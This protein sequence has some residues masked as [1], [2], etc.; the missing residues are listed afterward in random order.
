MN[1]RQ[2]ASYTLRAMNK[3][4]SFKLGLCYRHFTIKYRLC[5]FRNNNNYRLYFLRTE[6]KLYVFGWQINFIL[7]AMLIKTCLS[8]KNT[9]CRSIVLFVPRFM[10]PPVSWLRL[11]PMLSGMVSPIKRV[12]RE[13]RKGTPATGGNCSG[14]NCHWSVSLGS[15]TMDGICT[16]GIHPGY[17]SW[18]G[19]VPPTG[20]L[21]QTNVPLST[22]YRIN[23]QWPCRTE[24]SLISHLRTSFSKIGK[25]DKLKTIVIESLWTT[26]SYIFA[27]CAFQLSCWIGLS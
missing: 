12:E 23:L 5:F 25:R 10:A 19:A 21:T 18:A 8:I 27:F 9:N 1:L 3:L 17:L 14:G 26:D 7:A 2:N 20:G 22:C 6:F 24:R 16:C 15:S 11:S 4:T 13:A